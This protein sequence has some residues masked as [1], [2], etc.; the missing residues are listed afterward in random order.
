M[1][2]GLRTNELVEDIATEMNGLFQRMMPDEKSLLPSDETMIELMNLEEEE[3]LLLTDE[4]KGE[5][6][7]D[8]SSTMTR[9]VSFGGSFKL[10]WGCNV[11]FTKEGKK[12]SKNI[13]C[14]AKSLEGVGKKPG[15]DNPIH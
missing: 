6:Y 9:T 7:Y 4:G 15:E 12:M 11:T 8:P 5:V 1:S 10:F 2:I 13:E 3:L 14:G